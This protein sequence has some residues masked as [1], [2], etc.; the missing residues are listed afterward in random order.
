M[1]VSNRHSPRP[2]DLPTKRT[3][4]IG[5]WSSEFV[6]LDAFIAD[7]ATD[8]NGIRDSGGCQDFQ[9][10]QQGSIWL[11]GAP[12]NGGRDSVSGDGDENGRQEEQRD[13]GYLFRNA[14]GGLPDQ[15]DGE[16]DQN[17]VGNHVADA[18]DNE[19]HQAFATFGAGIRHDLPIMIERLTF[20]EGSDNDANI[21]DNEEAVDESKAILVRPGPRFADEALE[22]FQNGEFCDPD[23]GGV[24]NARGEDQLTSNLAVTNFL[25]RQPLCLYVVGAPDENDMH[26]AHPNHQRDDAVHHDPVFS[27]QSFG[28]H[29]ATEEPDQN[30]RQGEQG[31]PPRH[32]QRRIHLDP[33][34]HRRR[35]VVV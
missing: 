35:F 13:Q 17:Q 3:S 4:G 19:L 25:R 16:D 24:E 6:L 26:Q 9:R 15:R 18:H 32:D 33:R 12:V 7:E 2:G 1:V 29:P 30:G 34:L 22:E 21:G 11:G 27:K 31:T 20:G 5:R 10:S 8:D 28:A 23:V 14:H